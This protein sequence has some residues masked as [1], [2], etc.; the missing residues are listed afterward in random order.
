MPAIKL[1][2]KTTGKLEEHDSEESDQLVTKS[3]GSLDYPSP[4][5]LERLQ[6]VESHGTAAE[7]TLGALET[8]GR[9]ATFGA[10]QGV[11][12]AADI[13]AR[14]Q[15][16]REESPGVAFGA[17]AIGTVAP[18]VAGGAL[19]SGALAAAG[20]GAGVA[21]AASVAAEGAAG[22]LAGEVEEAQA[23][24]R[25]VSPG[26]A[27]LTGIGGEV[28]GRA[29]PAAIRAGVNRV[30]PA[31]S[32]ASVVA[33][34]AVA[35]VSQAAGKRARAQ[36]AEDA[37]HMP[38]GPDR[39]QA[40]ASTAEHQYARAD[41]ELQASAARAS[42]LLDSLAKSAPKDLE[43][44]IPKTTPGQVRW[45]AE[46]SAELRAM[47]ESA[48]EAH[49]A[50]LLRAAHGLVEADDAE[51]IWKAAG[52]ARERLRAIPDEPVAAPAAA[53][54]DD[55]E[56]QL[57]AS[58]EQAQAKKA[59]VVNDVAAAEPAGIKR[60][61]EGARVLEHAVTR[62]TP[63][64]FSSWD[65][66]DFA[67][68]RG[69]GKAAGKSAADYSGGARI[70]Q[71][72]RSIVDGLKQNQEFHAT[73]RVS[74]DA[75]KL[76]SEPTFVM[77][78]DGTVKLDHGRLRI[79]A[80]RE[81]GR[82]SVHGRVVQGRGKDAQVLYEGQIRVGN[83]PAE[84][85]ITTPKSAGD[86][87]V[88][89]SA[90]RAEQLI[91][92][93]Q[94]DPSLF[95]KAAEGAADLHGSAQPAP[96][97]DS[98]LASLEDQLAAAQRW[99]V[100]TDKARAELADHAQRMRGAQALRDDTERAVASVGAT[101]PQ[102]APRSRGGFHDML[103]SLASEGAEAAIEGAIGHAVPGLGLAF[104]GAK[105]LWK[106]MGDAGQAKVART[107]RAML[108][109]VTS[110]GRVIGAARASAGMTALQRFAGDAPDAR[111]AYESR[112]QMLT[113]VAANP[114]LAASVIAQSLQGLATENPS[115]FVALSQRLT[116]ALQYTALNLPPT[117]AV[118]LANPTGVPITDQELRD[119]ADLWN[120]AAEP[121]SALDDI[122]RLR[123]SPTQMQTLREMHG[124]I[125]NSVRTEL[126]MQAGQDF[127]S[128][129]SQTKL[130]LDIM[131]D[132]DGLGGLYTS[133][134][135]ARYV[136][137]AMNRSVA[138]GHGGA[139]AGSD[140]SNRQAQDSIEPAG[141]RA[142]RTGVTNKGA[143]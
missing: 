142:V 72:Q 115:N 89:G 120:T 81:V 71:Y 126:L 6:R 116:E 104:K 107:V 11:G 100:G 112:R 77:Q 46:T 111:S 91:A 131:F 37:Y 110:S 47:A 8:A 67:R 75:G 41:Q 36:L 102:P 82:D 18:A 55:L 118:S 130:S 13:A 21:G 68:G 38:P 95:G 28:L 88:S 79:T 129:P 61:S 30:L 138:K 132:A 15:T 23:Q 29:L 64:D 127:Q 58:V 76:G 133:N 48:P 42:E 80:A 134:E 60:T 49:R 9:T 33:G 3:G 86:S 136:S 62:E 45:A 39:D 2:N 143:V 140:K 20:A 128:I 73:G 25:P 108:S 19:A 121:A 59:G 103:G 69:A 125:Y 35:D 141:V 65:V 43:K 119:V 78:P 54:A 34:E 16:L 113:Q 114:Q 135:A 24:G 66:A 94:Q 84:P 53:P 50:E 98:P 5:Q 92:K 109:P 1:L 31:K 99:R 105:L 22:G 44:H 83:R 26:M 56:S 137:E 117:V 51:G 90:S 122:E 139:S 96:S 32:A 4:E 85:V 57:R 97:A 124:D 70:S 10:W 14:Q 52:E 12:P 74:G 7:Q 40:L 106:S 87:A 17:Q 101:A 63:P 27:L 93:G 123:A